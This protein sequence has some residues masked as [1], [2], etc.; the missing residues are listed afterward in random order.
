MY[1]E[2][3]Q[4]EAGLGGLDRLLDAQVDEGCVFGGGE[5]RRSQEDR[6]VPA[7]RVGFSPDFQNFGVDPADRDAAFDSKLDFLLRARAHKPGDPPIVMDTRWDKG[8]LIGRLMPV[9][10]RE[11]GPQLAI[12]TSTDATIE[13]FAKLGWPLFL[14]PVTRCGPRPS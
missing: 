10:Y 13:R 14:G 12:G 2:G 5:G 3:D 8:S 1:A 11:G 9:S 4:A 6:D 7:G